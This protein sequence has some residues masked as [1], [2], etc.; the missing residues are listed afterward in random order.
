LVKNNKLIFIG[1]TIAVSAG[2][3]SGFEGGL[4]VADWVPVRVELE[5]G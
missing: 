3:Q 4:P 1:G 2:K 5:V